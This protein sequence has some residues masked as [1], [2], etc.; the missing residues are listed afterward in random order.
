MEKKFVRSKGFTLVELLVVIAIIGILVALLLPAVQAAREAARRM[1]CSNNLKQVALALHNYHDT[2]KQMPPRAVGP[3]QTNTQG[4]VN[5]NL[6]WAVL[7]MPYVE[8]Q[9]ASDAITSTVKS[10]TGAGTV[11]PNPEVTPPN[12]M[13]TTNLSH[14]YSRITPNNPSA[15]E[16]GGFVC[17]SGPRAT[18]IPTGSNANLPAG[19]S[20]GP[21]GRLSYKACI[22]GNALGS[23][24]A[25]FW[26]YSARNQN[27]DGVFSYLRGANF[28]DMTD[29][30]SNVLV[31]GEV[32]MMFTQP[33]KYIGS[34][35]STVPAN[36]TIDPCVSGTGYNASTKMNLAPYTG[37]AAGVQ[38]VAW[39]AGN[40]IHSSF[41]TNYPPNGPSCAGPTNVAATT[42]SHINS[43]VIS[44]SSYHPGGCQAALGD[45]SV[46]FWSETLD[47]LTWRRLGDKADGQPVQID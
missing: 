8:G 43:A 2:F 35:S 7:T 40:P 32:A 26:P 28:A 46:R 22:G 20:S 44:A 36:A 33:G 24:A 39:T 29:G 11:L 6:S 13:T 30:T 14:L 42:T 37:G 16:F 38:S 9:S 23:T 34:V 27:A 1:S 31:I 45:G 4:M 15:F 25:A 47:A 5:G 19:Y 18:Q 21:M 12:T 3:I 10:A 41:S 17:P